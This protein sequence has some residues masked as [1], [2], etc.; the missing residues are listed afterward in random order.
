MMKILIGRPPSRTEGISRYVFVMSI[1]FL[2]LDQLFCRYPVQV[3]KSNNKTFWGK[4]PETRTPYESVGGST[5]READYPICQWHR[6]GGGLL[7]SDIREPRQTRYYHT[8]KR[9]GL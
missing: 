2:F 9:L 3:G 4:E 7:M 5:G 8:C 6:R 1:V